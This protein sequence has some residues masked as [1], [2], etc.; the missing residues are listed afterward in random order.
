MFSFTTISFAL[1]TVLIGIIV[2]W[3]LRFLSDQKRVDS[4]AKTSERILIEAEKS[5]ETIKKEKL[6]E[7][8]DKQL[9]L[10]QQF[11]IE[12][13]GRR[14]KLADAE[15]RLAERDLH[16]KHRHEEVDRAQKQIQQDENKLNHRS[17][18]LDRKQ[19][20]IGQKIFEANQQLERI[21]RMTQEEALE[22]LK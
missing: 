12:A 21:A 4:A 2:G 18:E 13:E 3:A 20:E 17:Q 8:K 5:A 22:Q 1:L 10:K 7:V 16:L 11:E 6:L 14:K 9:E 15:H 19:E